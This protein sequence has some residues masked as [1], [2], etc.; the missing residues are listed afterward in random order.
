[1]ARYKGRKSTKSIERDFPHIV[2]IA[3]PLGGL[4][5]RLDAMYDFHAM[6]GIQAQ[7][8]RGRRD[9]GRDY[10]TWCFADP[11]IANDFANMFFAI[12]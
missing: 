12:E 10:V 11:A 7:H 5:K 1:M 3:V 4:G 8:E 6:Y 2:E 9:N